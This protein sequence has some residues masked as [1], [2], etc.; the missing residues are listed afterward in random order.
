MAA[1]LIDAKG[2]MPRIESLWAYL[3]VDEDGDEGVIG[4]AHGVM[5][6]P[7]VAADETRLRGLRS[8]AKA[9]ARQ[10]GRVVRLVRFTVRQ[11]VEEIQP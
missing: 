7:L 2:A 3:S 11:D 4:R 9:V 5:W 8:T 1:I 10:T 6:V